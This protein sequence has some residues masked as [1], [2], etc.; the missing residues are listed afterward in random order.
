MVQEHTSLL[1][2]GILEVNRATC[3]RNIYVLVLVT[4]L[5]DTLRILDADKTTELNG[6]RGIHQ[7]LE[8]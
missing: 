5:I 2:Y 6:A 7:I 4:I 1:M 3:T 8:I